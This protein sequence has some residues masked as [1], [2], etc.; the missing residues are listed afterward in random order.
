M[1]IKDKDKQMKKFSFSCP[2]RASVLLF[3]FFLRHQVGG[4]LSRACVLACEMVVMLQIG[5]FNSQSYVKHIKNNFSSSIP[6][7]TFCTQIQTIL[8]LVCENLCISM[9]YNVSS[10]TYNV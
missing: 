9:V 3:D 2:V 4:I 7:V 8:R 1:R 6:I 10:N 5:D